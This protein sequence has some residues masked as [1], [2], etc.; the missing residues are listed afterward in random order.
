MKIRVAMKGKQ[1]LAA[2]ITLRHKKTLVYKYGCSDT[3]L[4]RFGGV[5]LLYWRCITEAKEAGM[6]RFDL[7]R[8]DAH[9]AGLITFKNRWGAQQSTL[10]YLR[11]PVCGSSTHSFDLPDQGWRMKMARSVLS[12]LRPGMLS[13]VGAMLYKH[14]G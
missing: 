8:T 12:R 13:A 3:R 7:G 11:Y 6:T 14:V 5:H 10:T 9:Q 4:H 2:M 1:P